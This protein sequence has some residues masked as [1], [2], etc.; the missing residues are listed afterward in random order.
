[1]LCVYC[2]LQWTR[3]AIGRLHPSQ[4]Q[5]NSRAVSSNYT[6]LIWMQNVA[7]QITCPWEEI[8]SNTNIP[9]RL[10]LVVHVHVNHTG[11][12]NTGWKWYSKILLNCN[13]HGTNCKY[14][15][16]QYDV[17]WMWRWDLG[18]PY[19]RPNVHCR[20]CQIFHVRKL[21]RLNIFLP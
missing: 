14:N 13:V 10:L 19:S 18:S 5:S 3:L 15:N 7:L 9:S 20:T 21:M 12:V 16:T 17:W 4:G 1:M 11:N 2:A 8:C 6:K